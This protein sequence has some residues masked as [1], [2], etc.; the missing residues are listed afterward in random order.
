MHSRCPFEDVDQVID[1][2]A[3]TIVA[4]QVLI[5]CVAGLSR[6]PVVAAQLCWPNRSI[7]QCDALDFYQV[8]LSDTLRWFFDMASWN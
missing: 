7:V 5:H 1:A 6:S 3:R 8:C 4:G 2:I